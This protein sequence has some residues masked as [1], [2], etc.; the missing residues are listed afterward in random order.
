MPQLR[1]GDNGVLRARKEDMDYTEAKGLSQEVL[2]YIS[3]SLSFKSRMTYKNFLD[4]L[5]WFR[6]YDLQ[7]FLPNLFVVIFLN[8]A[9]LYPVRAFTMHARM[10]YFA[11]Y[12][13][14][15]NIPV[16]EGLRAWCIDATTNNIPVQTFYFL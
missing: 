8:Y 4:I 16:D 14:A 7:Y 2:S 11:D 15:L 3:L 10:R 13:C 9:N 6:S 5:P 1:K 12:V